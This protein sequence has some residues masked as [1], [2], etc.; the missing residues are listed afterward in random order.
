MPGSPDFYCTQDPLQ[1]LIAGSSLL[2]HCLV[3]VTGG[4][5][6]VDLNLLDVEEGSAN[7]FITPTQQVIDYDNSDGSSLYHQLG[8]MIED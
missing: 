4:Q 3:Y 6:H 1:S 8:W 5:E 7:K 2:F